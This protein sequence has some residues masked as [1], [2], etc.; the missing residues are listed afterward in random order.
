MTSPENP[1]IKNIKRKRTQEDSKQ[2]TKTY[3]KKKRNIKTQ[4]DNI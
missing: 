3:K 4:N 2:G 1:S